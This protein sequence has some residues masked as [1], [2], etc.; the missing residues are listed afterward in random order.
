[1]MTTMPMAPS[2]PGN[3]IIQREDGMD[4]DSGENSTLASRHRQWHIDDDDHIHTF[5]C[6]VR[7]YET[8]AFGHANNVSFFAYLESARFDLFKKLR[9]FDP[10]NIFSLSLILARLECDYRAIARYNDV[11]TV[12]TRV[13][14]IGRSRFTLEHVLVRK[15]DETEVARGKAVLVAF[16]HVANRSIPIPEEMRQKLT[17]FQMGA[18]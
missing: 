1:M 12:Y 15:R 17:H 10:T 3:Y 13:E 14:E 4:R 9:L 2:M 18:H 8:D 6:D 11:L 5:V 16:D 7:L